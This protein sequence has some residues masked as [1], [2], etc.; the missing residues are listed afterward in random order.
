MIPL[1]EKLDHIAVVSIKLGLAVA[2]LTFFAV[3]IST[4]IITFKDD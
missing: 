4:L 1:H 2:I 3:F